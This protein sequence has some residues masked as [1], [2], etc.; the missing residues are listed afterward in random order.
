MSYASRETSRFSGEPFELYWFSVFGQDWRHTSGDTPRTHLGQTYTPLT[1]HRSAIDQNQELGSGSIKVTI[2]RDSSLAG[3]FLSYLP[4]SPMALTIYR[5]HDGESDGETVTN[6]TGRVASAVFG[7]FCELTVVPSQYVLKRRVPTLR[8]QSQ[9]NWALFGPGCGVDSTAFRV[10]GVVSNVNGGVVTATV[11]GTKPSGYFKAGYLEFDGARRMIV[12]HDGNEVTL[13]TAMAGL[14]A[15]A[16]VTA[17]A[18]CQ[19]T[20]SDCLNKFNNL[21]NHLG[22]ARIPTRN[23]FDKGLAG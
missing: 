15:G 16:T 19:R 23:P 9:C 1:I 22:F 4:V 12:D 18:G 14:T 13:L 11:F 7:E 3:Q 6:F 5:G 10:T 21:A 20:E 8:Q 17:Y 2:P